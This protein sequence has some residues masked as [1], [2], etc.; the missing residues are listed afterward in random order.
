[1]KFRYVPAFCLLLFCFCLYFCISAHSYAQAVQT[2][3]SQSFFR[4]HILANSDSQ[5]DQ[6]LKYLVRDELISYMN[7][8]CKD[9]SSKEEVI[10][11]ANAHQEDF[12]NIAENVIS[13]NGFSYPVNVEIGSF[14]FPTKHYG[15]LS[16]PAGIYDALRI[17]IGKAEGQNWWC[18]LFPPLCFISPATGIVEEENMQQIEENL[19]P[20]E[21]RLI[22]DSEDSSVRFQF[23]IVEVM[24]K[25]DTFFQK[26]NH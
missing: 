2:D 5:E 13:E 18:V 17:S 23:K 26:T 4:L 20:D 9:V 16:L 19:S 12:K 25:V 15:N 8:L 14:S 7:Q 10:R 3:L 6:A 11:L 22:S 1:M 21:V 24:H